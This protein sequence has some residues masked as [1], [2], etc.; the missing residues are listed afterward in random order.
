MAA[1]AVAAGGSHSRARPRLGAGAAALAGAAL[2]FLP[3]LP[4]LP[5]LA[6]VLANRVHHRRRGMGCL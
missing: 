3:P 4:L 5:G 6:R 2:L 1:T